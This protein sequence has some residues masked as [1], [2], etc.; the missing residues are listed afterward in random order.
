MIQL[1]CMFCLL[2]PVL[3]TDSLRLPSGCKCVI[4][5]EYRKQRQ[6]KNLCQLSFFCEIAEAA[7]GF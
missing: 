6:S 5:E 1:H 2:A 4:C 7:C 3:T